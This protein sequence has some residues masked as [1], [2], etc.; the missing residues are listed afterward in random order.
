[1]SPRTFLAIVLERCPAYKEPLPDCALKEIR[2]GGSDPEV[3]KQSLEKLS[4]EAIDQC[5]RR[6]FLC[7]CRK[8]GCGS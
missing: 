4:D 8:N 5:I 7:V 1:M 6:H 3:P 2:G